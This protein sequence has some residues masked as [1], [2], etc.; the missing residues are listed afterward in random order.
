MA[1]QTG[2]SQATINMTPMIDILL[3]L[4][5]IFLVITPLK[6]V[7]LATEVPREANQNTPQA[8]PPPMAVIRIDAGRNL[9]LNQKPY[10]SEELRSTLAGLLQR[11]PM[12]PVFID[13]A[14]ELEFGDVA[15]VIDMAKG[16]GATR[17]GLMP[18]GHRG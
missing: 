2:G 11:Y 10:T 9:S 15:A 18:G 17:I 12:L 1:M 6:P 16:A 5:I 13:G 14:P 8:P 4:L 7:G 3:V